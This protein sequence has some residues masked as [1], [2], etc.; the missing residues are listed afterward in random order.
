[1]TSLAGHTRPAGAA[2]DP[3][4]LCR[5]S[6]SWTA[7]KAIRASMHTSR[8]TCGLRTAE[9]RKTSLPSRRKTNSPAQEL[10]T[11]QDDNVD[12]VELAE[13]NGEVVSRPKSL[14]DDD[15]PVRESISPD[16]R[17]QHL[18]GVSCKGRGDCQD[19]QDF[20]QGK[21]AHSRPVASHF[22]DQTPQRSG[23]DGGPNRGGSD[24]GNLKRGRS[25]DGTIHR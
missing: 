25:S 3:L 24:F 15:T 14:L 4:S 5:S 8:R 23:S 18:P 17:R 20:S 6:T 22:A 13:P 1:M 2:A 16:A 9:S 10:L 19:R 7:V 21:E 12:R 11:G